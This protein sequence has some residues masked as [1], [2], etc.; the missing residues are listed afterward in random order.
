MFAE[1]FKDFALSDEKFA[2]FKIDASTGGIFPGL[3]GEAGEGIVD[4]E[5]LRRGLG[6]VFGGGFLRVFHRVF[7]K[8]IHRVFHRVILGVGGGF[9]K[10]FA[11]ENRGV[12]AITAKL[13]EVARGVLRESLL[14]EAE[15]FCGFVRG[16]L[17]VNGCFQVWL[18]LH[19]IILYDYSTT[20]R[21]SERGI[22]LL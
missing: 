4:P 7:R 1:F 2:G 19:L 17:V 14:S 16:N 13:N 8:V 9:L 20:D 15:D 5:E 21:P 22:I 6:L 10:E 12:T 3:L 18:R 11:E